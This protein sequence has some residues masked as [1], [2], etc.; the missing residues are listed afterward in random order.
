VYFINFVPSTIKWSDVIQ[1]CLYAIGF[2]LLATIYPAIKAFK[3][4]PAEA[5]RYE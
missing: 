2:S 4:Q 3:T 5:L 1:V